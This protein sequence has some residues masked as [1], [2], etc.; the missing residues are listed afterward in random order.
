VISNVVFSMKIQNC[1][2]KIN[3]DKRNRESLYVKKN[4]N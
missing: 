4:A 2:F 1:K 3:S